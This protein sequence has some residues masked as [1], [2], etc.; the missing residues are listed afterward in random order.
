VEDEKTTRVRE[1][2]Y[3]QPRFRTDFHFLLQTEGPRPQVLS[4]RCTD[5]SEEGLAAF[6]SAELDVG[7]AVTF[8]L[9]LPEGATS[10]RLN[11]TV[12]YRVDLCHGFRF[13]LSSDR[14]RE[15]VQRYVADLR[16]RSVAFKQPQ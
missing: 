12:N 3:R 9:T 4:A 16:S 13:M 10:I 14:E 2:G 7:T 8:I 1:F 5:L 6:V 15:F 11:A